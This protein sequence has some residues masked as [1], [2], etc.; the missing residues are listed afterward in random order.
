MN[1]LI[2][3]NNIINIKQ[4]LLTI[5]ELLNII[6]YEYNEIFLDKF[7]KNIKD[8]IWIYIDNN[9]LKYIGYEQSETKQDYLHILKEN[10]EENIDYKFIL[11]K[12]FEDFSKCQKLILRNIIIN[13][14]NKVNHL[15]ISPDCFK[16]SLM[17]LK[18]SRSKEIKK[19]YIEL[20]KIFKFYLKYQN[21]YRKFELKNKQNEI[22]EKETIIS[23]L[24][25][26]LQNIQRI[27][28]N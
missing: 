23:K 6:N 5:K 15:I 3:T 4:P 21:K 19:N 9:M 17:L 12:E 1:Q 2:L 13:E 18:T 28:R 8:D 27:I 22:E 7:W 16:E 14:H 25:A 26:S 24:Y 11:S 10:F 20:G